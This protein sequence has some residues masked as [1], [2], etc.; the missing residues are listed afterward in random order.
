MDELPGV[1]FG[2]LNSGC[3]V[4]KKVLFGAGLVVGT[5]SVRCVGSM[6]C[7]RGVRSTAVVLGF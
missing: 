7:L 3:P 6:S 5:A 2:V 4:C 1:L